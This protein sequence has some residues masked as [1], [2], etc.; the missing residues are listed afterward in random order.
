MRNAGKTGIAVAIVAAALAGSAFAAAEETKVSLERTE[1]G[2]KGK[3]D[4]KSSF[5]RDRIVLLMQKLDGEDTLYQSQDSNPK[6]GVWRISV[7]LEPGR[8]YARVGKRV[9]GRGAARRPART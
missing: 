7:D 3:V 2:V 9:E 8:Y 5:C 6:T 4:A 1:L